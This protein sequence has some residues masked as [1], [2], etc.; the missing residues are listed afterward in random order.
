MYLGIF[1]LSFVV[2]YLIAKIFVNYRFLP[3]S[4]PNSRSSHTIPTKRGGGIVF[5]MTLVGC[6]LY[7]AAAGLPEQDHR[8][9]LPLMAIGIFSVIG[10]IDDFRELSARTR[11][12]AEIAVAIAIV[13]S[14]FYW[15][16]IN[17]YHFSI[18][19]SPVIGSIFTI[20]WIL[21]VVNLFNFMDG[22]N[23]IAAL[24]G[25]IA[26]LFYLAVSNSIAVSAITIAIIGSLV[27]FLPFN[28]PKAKLFMGDAGS[29]LLGAYVAVIPIV[30]HTS[31]PSFTLPLGMAPILPFIFDSTYTLIRRLLKKE[32]VFLAHRTH[33]YQLLA[34]NW[35]G[36]VKVTILYAILATI[37]STIGYFS[38]SKSGDFLVLFLV[39]FTL[40][41]FFVARTVD[42]RSISV[43]L[44]GKKN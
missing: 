14:G 30:F 39:I 40:A 34:S 5:L 16:E 26:T 12:L 35:F 17:F 24:Q 29:L 19:F 33:I 18:K 7:F 25:L 43:S 10:C 31:D 4:Q 38:Y 3:S 37:S 13:A 21:W 11:M 41:A 27:A 15:K 20:L 23:G 8:F 22:I 1:L 6:G 28:F 42:K 2:N 36:H 9:W 32:K 44:S